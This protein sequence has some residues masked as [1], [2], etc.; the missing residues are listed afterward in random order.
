MNAPPSVGIIANPAAGKDIRRLV[1]HGRVVPDW[2]K[3][4]IIRRALI[5]LA[6]T[7]V[8]RIITMPDSSNLCG[9]AA[10]VQNLSMEIEPLKMPISG[11][12]ADTIH[13]ADMMASLGIGCLISLGGDGTNRA[14]SKGCGDVPL[15]PISTGTNN[16]FPFM[17]EGT[18]A[19]IAA[20]V[21]AR[22]LVDPDAVCAASKLLEVYVDDVRRDVALV[23]VAVSNQH[24][25]ASRAIWDPSTL[26]EVF[27]TRAE[28]TSLGLSSIGARIHPISMDDAA[29]LHFT[30]GK[31]VSSVT[32]PIAPG[33]ID[34]VPI[35]KWQ[36]LGLGQR[37]EVVHDHCTIALDGEREFPVMSHQKLEIGLSGNGPKVVILDA[38]LRA[39]A[40]QGVFGE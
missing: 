15:I 12:A 2:E 28:L 20:G 22:R 33:L 24:H 31:G 40:A 30:V 5:G 32:A 13:A 18:L 4:N 29:G 1:A 25:V 23:D 11:G 8:R 6:S 35:Q 27:L 17:M 10:D 37:V 14:I 3:T 36:V 21:V 26:Q 39:A 9:K 38:A 34:S 7:G 19:G 16:V